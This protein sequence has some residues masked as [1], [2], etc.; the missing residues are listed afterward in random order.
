[1]FSSF[2][3]PMNFILIF[4]AFLLQMEVFVPFL[5]SIH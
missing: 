3:I 1:M 5:Y 4:S 2:Y